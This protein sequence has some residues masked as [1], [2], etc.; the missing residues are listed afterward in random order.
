VFVLLVV[1]AN[2]REILLHLIHSFLSFANSS[3]EL[4]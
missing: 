3:F 1:L 2:F 4:I